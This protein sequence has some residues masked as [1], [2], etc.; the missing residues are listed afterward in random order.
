M[1]R[2]EDLVVE[3]DLR[4]DP[5]RAV[6]GIDWREVF[7]RTAPVEVEVGIGKGR[8]LLAVAAARPEVDHLGI[9]WANKYLRI[10]ESR[11]RKRGLSNVR[12][13]RADAREIIEDGAMPEGSV[14]AFHVFY[15]DPWP[16]KRH[17]KRRL[18]R[19]GSVDA[20]ARALEPGGTLHVATDFAD[21]WEVIE[22]LLDAHPAFDR[23]PRF[24][25]ESFP[26]PTDAPLTNYETKYR[27][28]GRGRH[29]A[30]WRRKKEGRR[31]ER[32]QKN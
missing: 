29:R 11:A 5:E 21:Y 14:R 8:F 23:L 17:H 25:G 28:E 1:R 15:P 19:P 7:G 22:S 32:C 10:A 30:S 18:F 27:V 4:L 12:F 26:L 6:E 2:G 9:E 3:S 31:S 13:V 16:K 20:L 24:G